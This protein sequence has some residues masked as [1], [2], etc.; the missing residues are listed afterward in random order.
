MP[1]ARTNLG[2]AGEAIARRYLEGHGFE[3]IESNWRCRA[4]ELDLIMRDGEF[5]VFVEVKTRRGDAA[6]RAEDAIS[7]A[8]G[9]KLAAAGS[10]YLADHP[11]LGDPIWRID[12][13]AITLSHDGNLVRL[14]HMENA[15]VDG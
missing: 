14:A 6:G 3:W 15:V 12:L 2:N 10:W 5:L 4:G 13:I 7:P 1:T 8:K 11:A 9:R